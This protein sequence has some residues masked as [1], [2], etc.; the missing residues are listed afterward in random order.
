MSPATRNAFTNQL[1][2]SLSHNRASPSRGSIPALSPSKLLQMQ[3]G[4]IYTFNQV[5]QQT[6][7]PF[8]SPSQPNQ[9]QMTGTFGTRSQSILTNPAGYTQQAQSP[10]QFQQVQP[11]PVSGV[12]NTV[13][14][15]PTAGP[16]QSDNQFFMLNATS[17]PFAKENTQL[18][19]EIKRMESAIDVLLMKMAEL[20]AKKSKQAQTEAAQKGQQDPSAA[21]RQLRNWPV[22]Y[23]HLTLPTIYSV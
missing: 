9:G 14:N 12:P 18:K 1:F 5:Q 8:V 4:G 13:S 16:S 11:R 22:S 2:S 17:N 3:G 15:R 21:G 10:P 7:Q 19:D 20:R 23:T 6:Q